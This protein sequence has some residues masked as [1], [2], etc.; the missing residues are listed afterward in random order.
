MRVHIKIFLLLLLAVSCRKEEG[1]ITSTN[2]QVTYPDTNIG[3]VKGLFLLNEGNMGSNKA[4][5]DYFDYETGI[6]SKNIYAERNP[7]VV[8]ELGDVGNDIEVYDGKIYAVIN[9]SNLIEVM[10]QSSAKHIGSVSIPNCRYIAFNG[11]YAYVTSYAGTMMGDGYRQGYVAKVELSTLNVVGE[12]AV[13]YQPEQLEVVGDKLYVANSGGY[14][15]PNYDNRV[16]VIDLNSFTLTKHIE[17][18]VNLQDLELD[19]YGYLWISSR[20]D[21]DTTPSKTYILNTDNDEVVDELDISNSN[22]ARF[23]DTIY[24]IGSQYDNSDSSDGVNYVAVDVVSREV[25]STNFISDGTDDKIV[26]PYSIA[27][28]PETTEILITDVKDYITPGT[29]YCYSPSGVLKWS[30]TTG[31]IPSSIAFTTTAL[32]SNT[33][34]EEEE[35]E[36]EAPEESDATAYIT[37]VIEYRPAPGQ[38]VGK[39]PLYE[40][41]DTAESMND[42]ALELI[43]NNTKGTVTLGGYGGYITVG[44]DHTIENIAGKCDFRVTG[45]ATATSSEPGII[46]VAYDAND[47]GVADDD[48]WY[49]IAGSSHIDVTQESFYEDALAAGNDM[50]FYYRD[51][52]ITYTKPLS[53]PETDGYSTYIP[54]V[55]NKG[56]SGYIVK[57]GFNKQPYFPQWIDEETLTF[58]GSRLP[59]NGIDTSGSGSSFVLYNL[60]YGYADNSAE[61]DT[62]I[63]ISMARDAAGESVTLPGVD[64]IKIYTG[65]NQHNGWIGENSTELVNVEDLHILGE[66][67]ESD[68]L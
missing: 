28:N 59:Q 40:D 42:K 25:I 60:L 14:N 51:F 46:M 45:N 56:G 67:I 27:I 61:G 29:L 17:V 24:M 57:N 33:E 30:V 63:D 50:N 38:F 68:Y 37:K 3:D 41:G 6:Y 18:A 26:V 58:N 13:G 19:R 55:D 5:L 39:L 10:E 11:D 32:Q 35:E 34:G 44:F 7:D 16:S 4:T 31:D 53:E 20:G 2:S 8:Y 12:C 36:P 52:E 47:N 9:C 1:I 48:E 64:F 62:T 21:Y 43:G 23:E 65:V 54:W 66:S 49:E 15:A 22:M